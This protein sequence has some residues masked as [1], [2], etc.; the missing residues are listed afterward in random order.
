MF[1]RRWFDNS[2]GVYPFVKVLAAEGVYRQLLSMSV[3]ASAEEFQRFRT[4]EF[5]WHDLEA[6]FIVLTGMSG[7][8]DLGLVFDKLPAQMEI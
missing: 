7:R 2:T 4:R 1:L 8:A 6:G 5:A 3:M